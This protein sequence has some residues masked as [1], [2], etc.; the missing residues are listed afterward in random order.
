M[1]TASTCR[2]PCPLCLE[3]LYTPGHAPGH[4]C[5]DA[6][7]SGAMITGDMVASVGTILIQPEDGDMALYLASLERMRDR[8]PRVLLPA[9]G[10][11]ID[12]PRTCLDRY[13]AHRLAREAKVLAARLTGPEPGPR[14]PCRRPTTTPRT[15]SGPSPPSR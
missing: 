12:D 13:V 11:P 10:E 9:H 4:L 8:Q 3:A 14:I 7:G 6:L 5:F 15:R 1:A 2:G